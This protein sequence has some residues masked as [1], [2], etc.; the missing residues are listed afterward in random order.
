MAEIA[1]GAV[2]HLSG[3]RVAATRAH[4]RALDLLDR[5][6]ILLIP[7]GGRVRFVAALSAPLCPPGRS[8]I[9]CRMVFPVISASAEIYRG[10]SADRGMATRFSRYDVGGEAGALLSMVGEPTICRCEVRAWV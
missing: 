2:S 10:V 9:S 5:V 7:Q 4:C 3:S 8:L 6:L 1:E